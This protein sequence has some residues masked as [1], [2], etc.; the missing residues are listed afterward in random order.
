MQHF[1]RLQIKSS[2]SIPNLLCALF[3]L[4]E[5]LLNYMKDIKKNGS[6]QEALNEISNI[7]IKSNENKNLDYL[8]NENRQSWNV[9]AQSWLNNNVQN[10]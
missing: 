4:L 3:I 5:T 8:L 1:L 6:T 9:N 7:D 10:T 2:L